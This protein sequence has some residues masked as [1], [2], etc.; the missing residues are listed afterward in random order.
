MLGNE[1]M[2]KKK[3]FDTIALILSVGFLVS[4]C[5][6]SSQLITET[7]P[8]STNTAIPTFALTDTP[9][10][11]ST[12]TETF[13]S[14]PPTLTP[15]L[16]PTETFTPAPDGEV[17]FQT[18]FAHR[19]YPGWTYLEGTIPP[20]SDDGALRPIDDFWFSVGSD[21]WENYRVTVEFVSTPGCGSNPSMIFV[22]AS[23]RFTG[24]AFQI[25]DDS[26]NLMRV[27]TPAS[28]SYNDV[29]DSKV[30]LDGKTFSVDVVDNNYTFGG[31][32]ETAEG[33]RTGKVYF[34]FVQGTAFKEITIT[35]L[36]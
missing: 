3:Y 1:A 36:P 15:S 13:T 16:T 23:D 31:L 19:H 32:T 10:P 9:I 11:P 35:Q 12:A 7:P 30:G 22:R 8:L 33:N 24:V 25:C 14:I 27:Y 4:G 5:G 28:G 17:L 20:I 26:V 29:P 2:N 21:T 34:E 6:T 18:D